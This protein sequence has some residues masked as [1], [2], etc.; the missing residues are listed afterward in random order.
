MANFCVNCGSAV[1]PTAVFCGGCGTRV[2]VAPPAPAAASLA[3]VV[4]GGFTPVPTGYMASPAAPAP[5]VS[6]T[7][8]FTA[9]SPVPTPDPA[10]F[11]PVP[12][13]FA[14]P[15]PPPD[16]APFTPVTP[17]PALDSTG[18]TPVSS[19]LTPQAAAP[20]PDLAGFV[21][22]QGD[23]APVPPSPTP[24]APT[25][26][27]TP[28]QTVQP[29]Y[30]AAPPAYTPTPAYAPATAYSAKKSNTLLKVVIAFV[31][32]L[33]VGA[34][35]AL[36]GLWYAA[37]KIKEKAHAAATQAGI[38]SGVLNGVTGGHDSADAGAFK[39]DPCGILSK[40]EVSQAIGITVIRA[41]AKDG[42]CSY[43]AKGD[44]ADATAKH[45]SSMLGGLGADPKA[46]KMIQ[47]M[48]KGLFAQQQATDK[49]LSAQAATGE[50]PVLVT[51]YSS[52]NAQMEMKMDHGA[53]SHATGGVGTAAGSGS[54]DLDRIGDEAYVAGGSMIIFRKGNTT[55]HFTY[56]SCPCNTD[57]IKPLA[58]LAASRL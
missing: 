25:S 20:T 15:T 37:Q 41:D 51:R 27:Y 47:K 52:G 19:S 23:F 32:L 48:A 46:Q 13:T 36:G 24:V 6:A 39:G 30:A 43:I 8:N 44:P 29:P 11:A 14:S 4:Q 58:K 34:V 45:M 57:N 56:I 31:L 55:A 1:N 7:G 12:S 21:P 10:G 28:V 16:P 53:F 42:G 5:A 9:V 35:L 38:L 26:A 17:V 54:G 22:V 50:I 3:P 40:E 18:F 33:C 49:G 2:P